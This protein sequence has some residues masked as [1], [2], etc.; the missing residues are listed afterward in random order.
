MSNHIYAL[1]PIVEKYFND[2]IFMVI[3]RKINSYLCNVADFTY[4]PVLYEKVE[5]SEEIMTMLEK[6]KSDIYITQYICVH[7]TI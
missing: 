2:P 1:H 7:L 5:G 4:F 6:V 3:K